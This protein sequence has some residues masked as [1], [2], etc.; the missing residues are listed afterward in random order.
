MSKMKIA[1]IGL[2]AAGAF[3]A[4]AAYDR[5]HEV[6]IYAITTGVMS[7][8]A[9]WLHWVPQDIPQRFSATQI[10]VAGRGTAAN[11]TK[12]QWGSV[13]PTSSFPA[14]PVWETGYNPTQVLDALVPAA[15]NVNSIPYPMSDAEIKDL[16]VAFDMV[17]QTF[18]TRESKEQQPALLS[19]VAAAQFDACDPGQNAV[20]YN[21]TK[22]GIVVREAQL[23]GNRFLE[24][25]KNMTLEEVQGQYDLKDWKTVVLK[26]L[27]L[28]TKP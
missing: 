6:E 14:Q 11:Y 22:Q 25:P 24:F 19:F 9:T 28:R 15:C 18:A 3:A 1:I 8:G 13:Q 27:D 26:D 20:V 5:G 7:P 21:G 4:R 16:S 2:G 23:W 12:R 10:Y 17:F